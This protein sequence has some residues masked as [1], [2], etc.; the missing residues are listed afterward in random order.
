MSAGLP[1]KDVLEEFY[2]VLH[3][4]PAYLIGSGRAGEVVNFMAASWVTPVSEEPPRVA[5]AIGVDSYTHELIK[6]YREFSINVYPLEKVDVLYACGS[7]SGR[8]VDKVSE[9]GLKVVKG[10]R[11]VAPVLED[12]LATLECEVWKIMESGDTSLVVGDVKAAYASEDAFESGRGWR[13]N[14]P[15][16]NWG[17]GFYG[18]GRFKLAKRFSSR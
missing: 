11:I 14:I 3:P 6:R 4:R 5:V 10:R 13:V 17:R 7:L 15:L 9:L 16:H 1:M 12:A 2:L 8:K 18:L